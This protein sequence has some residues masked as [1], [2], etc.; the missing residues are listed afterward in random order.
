MLGV[1]FDSKG[2]MYVLQKTT[3]NPDPTPGTGSIVRIVNGAQEV[4]VSGL[5]LPTGDDLRA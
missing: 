2:R 5:T 1:Q 3:G 4:I